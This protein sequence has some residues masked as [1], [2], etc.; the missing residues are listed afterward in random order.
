MSAPMPEAPLSEPNVQLLNTF[1][2]F[3]G[4]T[5]VLAVGSRTAGE[6]VGDFEAFLNL[7][8]MHDRSPQL[9]QLQ[10]AS[11]TSNAVEHDDELSAGEDIERPLEQSAAHSSSTS[12]SLGDHN[13][14]AAATA[15]TAAAV[16]AT[17]AA[18]AAENANSCNSLQCDTD[19]ATAAATAAAGGGSKRKHEQHKHQHRRDS[20]ST[21]GSRTSSGPTGA[22]PVAIDCKSSGNNSCDNNSHSNSSASSGSRKQRRTD[23][24]CAQ[25][26]QL[27]SEITAVCCYYTDRY[28][29]AV[30]S[31]CCR[32]YTILRD[33]AHFS[34][35]HCRF[36][37][38]DRH[39]YMG[40][41]GG[42]PQY[43]SQHATA[44][45]IAGKPVP[46]AYFTLFT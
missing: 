29:R 26:L 32:A 16:P 4:S 15:V 19:I 39:A 7:Y 14:A 41:Q 25:S 42:S 9:V 17:A 33:D 13:V 12:N 8:N 45:M 40:V 27:T 28:C 36:D 24:H 21:N 20:S 38:C 18:A 1:V 2:A 31:V 5:G 10:Q 6:L 3:L 30:G 44:T 37:G 43:C 22:T 46:I 35:P 23:M 34:A 11:S